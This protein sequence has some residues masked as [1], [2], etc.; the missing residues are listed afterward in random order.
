MKITVLQENLKSALKTIQ[1]AIPSK[2]QLPILS[3]V[4][5]KADKQGVLTLAATDLYLGIKGSIAAQVDE[6][7]ELV[8]PGDLFKNLIF[9]LSVGELILETKGSSLIIKYGKSRSSLPYQAAED[10][11]RFPNID[12]DEYSFSVDQLN[13]VE[14]RVSFAAA[15]DQA[16]PALSS[17]YFN[18]TADSPKIVATDGFRLMI[19]D[20]DSEENSINRNLLIPKK[21][22]SEVFR[23]MAQTKAEKLFFKVSEELK[24]VLFSIDGTEIYVRL[25]DGEYP[26]YE[27]IIPTSFVV[28][29]KLDLETLTDEVKRAHIFSKEASNIV[30]FKFEEGSLTI[31]SEGSGSGEYKGE[32]EVD[33]KGEPLEVSF[34][35]IYLLDFL[36][37]QKEG[38]LIFQM[39]ESLKPIQLQMED[40]PQCKYIVMPF[41]A[42]G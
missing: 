22:M 41:R 7:G 2:P 33:Y 9:S 21:A 12:G 4:Y 32:V 28:N 42:N 38:T 6:P 10:Y 23:M 17:L 29:L 40:F 39:N 1:K 36:N 15:T 3:S 26:P 25:I 24:Q 34:N 19:M 18:F 14:K 5:L 13:I 37:T 8:V 16:R 27:K 20:L 31:F 11:P 30:K 35:A